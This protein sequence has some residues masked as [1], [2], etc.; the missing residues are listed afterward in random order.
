MALQTVE[1]HF[2]AATPAVVADA[3][4]AVSAVLAAG[5]MMLCCA[6]SRVAAAVAAVA[7]QLHALYATAA[8]GAGV[9]F[10]AELAAA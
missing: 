5:T 6:K 2:E 8:A 4:D 1:V 10:V 9:G 3:A 7:L